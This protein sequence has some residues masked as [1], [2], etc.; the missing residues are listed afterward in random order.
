MALESALPK[1]LDIACGETSTSDIPRVHAFNVVRVI[2][3][4]K[5]LSVDTTPHASRGVQVCIDAFSSQT[6]EVSLSLC[7]AHA[8]KAGGIVACA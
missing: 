1:L 6:W 2:F 3:A 4:D 5:D 7:F 8:N